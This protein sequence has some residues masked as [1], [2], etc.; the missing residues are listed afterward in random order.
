MPVPLNP[1]FIT[2]AVPELLSIVNVPLISPTDKGFN[3]TCKVNDCLGASVTG[4]MRSVKEKSAPVTTTELT[5]TGAVPVE[6]NVSD[7]ETDAPTVAFP[8]LKVPAL[9]VN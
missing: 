4:S 5:V 3:C 7:C 6:V 1:I 8:K 9:T 2:L